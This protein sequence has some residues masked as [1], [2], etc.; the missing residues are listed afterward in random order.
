MSEAGP[1]ILWSVMPIELVLEGLAP[2]MPA[3]AEMMLDGRLLEVEPATDGSA[4]VV[5]LI[6]PCPGDYL[7]PRFQPGARVRMG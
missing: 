6:S 3:R 5:R 4:M 1:G 7:D 2:A